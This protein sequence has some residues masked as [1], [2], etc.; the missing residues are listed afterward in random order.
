MGFGQNET[1]KNSKNLY[2]PFIN[3]WGCLLQSSAAYKYCTGYFET[4]FLV[5]KKRERRPGDVPRLQFTDELDMFSSFTN[6]VF[7]RGFFWPNSGFLKRSF[8]KLFSMMLNI[9]HKC[10]NKES[11]ELKIFQGRSKSAFPKQS[12]WYSFCLGRKAVEGS[13]LVQTWVHGFKGLRL[14]VSAPYS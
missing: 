6:T 2:R 13:C 1:S 4:E 3:D 11:A 12:R 7:R 8:L 9:K 14:G 10:L 5:K